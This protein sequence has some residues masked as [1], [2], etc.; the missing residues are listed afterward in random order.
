MWRSW[1]RPWDSGVI[2]KA[3]AIAI[4]MTTAM[5]MAIAK[6]VAITTVIAMI[7]NRDMAGMAKETRP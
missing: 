7:K 6:A 1:P 5:A 3:I 2:A 4:A